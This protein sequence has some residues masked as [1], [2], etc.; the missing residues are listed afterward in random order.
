L[1]PVGLNVAVY[2][3]EIMDQLNAGCRGQRR[4]EVSGHGFAGNKG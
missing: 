2:Q 4:M 3:G 1:L